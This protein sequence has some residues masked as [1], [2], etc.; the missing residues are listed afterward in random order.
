LSGFAGFAGRAGTGQIDYHLAT[1]LVLGAV[2][3]AQLGGWLSSKLDAVVLSGVLGIVI[4]ITAI[5]MLVSISNWYF[6][7]L[8]AV[9][10]IVIVIG[11]FKR[12]RPL[13]KKSPST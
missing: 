3:A 12:R 7:G 10:I 5:R 6:A 11:I 8:S 1:A 4:G 2:P 9:G 13:S